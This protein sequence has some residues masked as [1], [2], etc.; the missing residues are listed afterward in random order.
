MTS[1]PN[2]T[3]ILGVFSL[4]AM[5]SFL[6]SEVA[7]DSSVLDANALN[8]AVQKGDIETARTLLDS[9]VD[10]NER[11][12]FGSFA[13]NA[14][15]VENDIPLL[16]LLVE[17]GANANAQSWSG[18]TAL[19]CATKYAGG[20]KDTVKLLLDAGTDVSLKDEDGKTALDYA[21]EKKQAEAL[22]LL[23]KSM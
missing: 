11:N 19:I 18:D 20:K 5:L 7:A 17:R 9:G 22:A 3:K 4:I 1:R 15:A 6:G 16:R 10:V 14:A 12:K 8:T 13:L 23:E 21:K 2:K